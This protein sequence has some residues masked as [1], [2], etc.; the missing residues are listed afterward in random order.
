[1]VKVK[2]EHSLV[3]GTRRDDESVSQMCFVF[4]DKKILPTMEVS[5][6]EKQILLYGGHRLD[7]VGYCVGSDGRCRS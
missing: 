6:Y 7:A 1:M 4:L 3:S 2:S 5:N